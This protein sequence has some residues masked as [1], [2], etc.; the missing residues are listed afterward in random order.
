M[1]VHHEEQRRDRTRRVTDAAWSD[2]DKTMER[3]IDVGRGEKQ[4]EKLRQRGRGWERER[5]VRSERRRRIVGSSRV[6]SGRA[7]AV[8]G[9]CGVCR[10][11]VVVAHP[12]A[13]FAYTFNHHPPLSTHP[14]PPPPQFP[15]YRPLLS[16]AHPYPPSFIV[17][18]RH[19]DSFSNSISLNGIKTILLRMRATRLV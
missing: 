5:N 3:M 2:R 10:T 1:V 8:P 4:R 12:C 11:G 14:P 7:G 9:S 15:T 13:P 6:T 18:Y 16:S 17:P 19:I